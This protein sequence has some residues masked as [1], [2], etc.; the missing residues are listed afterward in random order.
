MLSLESRRQLALAEAGLGN[1][2]AAMQTLDQLIA[3]AG[4]NPMLAG[5]LHKARAELALKLSDKDAFEQ[6]ASAMEQYFRGTRNPALIAQCEQLS[7]AAI[8]AGLRESLEPAPARTHA[9]WLRQAS[10]Q[11]TLEQLTAAADRGE[12]ALWLIL[13]RSLAKS[14]YLYVL[15]HDGWR[16]AAAS[17]RREAP[18]GLEQELRALAERA[19]QFPQVHEGLATI[20]I[21]HVENSDAAVAESPSSASASTQPAGDDARVSSAAGMR[22]SL[23]PQAGDKTVFIDSMPAPGKRS[24]HQV[25]L[26]RASRGN[27][28]FVVGGLILELA[29]SEL[30][31]LGTELLGA[32]AN[33][34]G[35]RCITTASEALPDDF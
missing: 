32:V 15:E 25:L 31:R 5:L 1:H 13:E 7:D 18:A 29:A 28:H 8:R 30:G 4:D 22:A 20:A 17:T 23:D 14:G 21:M 34:L 10:G 6:H 3:S 11:R 27:Q 19:A 9:A 35:D 24:E 16:L 26:L 12:Y 33:A 2:A